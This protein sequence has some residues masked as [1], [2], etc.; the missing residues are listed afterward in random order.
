MVE[1]VPALHSA[2]VRCTDLR[3]GAALVVA[4]LGAEGE[5]KITQIHHILRGYENFAQRLSS[6]GA[7]VRWIQDPAAP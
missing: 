4:A 6:L 5:S 1:G 3:G 7:D 2:Q